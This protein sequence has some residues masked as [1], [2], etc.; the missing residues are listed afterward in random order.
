MSTLF[1]KPT[2]ILGESTKELIL[3][4]SSLKFQW[5]NKFIELIK[6]GKLNVEKDNILKEADSIDSISKDGI[7][8]VGD[9]IIICING[10]KT[11]IE[12]A[13]I[14]YISYLEEQ[15]ELTPEQKQIALLNSGF[16]YKTLEEA[17][18]AKIKSGIIFVLEDNTFYLADKETLVPYNFNTKKE[19]VE[20]DIKN[21]FIETSDISEDVSEISSE[22]STQDNIIINYSL[23]EVSKTMGCKLQKQN[24]FH[25]GDS[26]FIE[27]DPIII[28][29]FSVTN[30]DYYFSLSDI[31]DTD[32]VITYY[33]SEDT[34]WQEKFTI[35]KG[36][37]KSNT[38]KKTEKFSYFQYDPLDKKYIKGVVIDVNKSLNNSDNIFDIIVNTI[39]Y[40]NLINKKIIGGGSSLLPPNTIMI[41]YGE[42]IPYG[43]VK[44]DGTNN[45]PNLPSLTTNV[46]YIMK[47]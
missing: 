36:N 28:Q 26:I 37:T 45:T 24:N 25:I 10:N 20:E 22:T 3:K 14:S 41:Y 30:E 1:G 4:G 42:S 33:N 16:Y 21:D 15:T 44:C 34:S 40:S 7:Y 35:K 2:N 5:G 6:E 29:E 8:L 46:N 38:F 18:N 39:S 47:L 9:K 17:K 43:W 32:V 12:K 27:C 19:I 31:Y 13:I 11:T 23:D